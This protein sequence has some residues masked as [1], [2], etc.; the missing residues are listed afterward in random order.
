MLNE[1]HDIVGINSLIPYE[2]I[3]KDKNHIFALSVDT[4]TK[5][6]YRSLSSF[7]KMSKTVYKEAKTDGISVVFGF[8]NDTSYKIFKR[9]LKWQ[10]IGMLSFYIL[11]ITI[12]NI[13]PVPYVFNTLS[14][15]YSR[16]VCGNLLSS[17]SEERVEQ[18]KII[19]CNNTQFK[20]QRYNQEYLF[21]THG[22]YES[23]YIISEFESTKVAYLVDCQPLSKKNIE[24]SVS[25]IYHNH[26]NEIDII[27]YVGNTGYNLVNM[28]KVPAKY[29]PKNIYMSAL[30]L[31][32]S[33]DNDIF[34]IENWE[35]N[36]SNFDVI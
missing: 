17:I 1:Q 36:L 26:K 2:Y 27:I 30:K 31:D 11:P 24:S 4:M 8:P 25:Y 29:Q 32:D 23:R 34:D 9:M 21:I 33:I 6:K 3:V 12:S 28:I 14:W 18:K 16:V 5:K 7:V 35:I 20:K 13:K 22:N 15:L 19:K 10:D